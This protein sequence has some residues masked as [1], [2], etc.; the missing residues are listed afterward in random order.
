MI[1]ICAW[2]QKEG[3]QS[4]QEQMPE[5]SFGQISHGICRNHALSLRHTFRRSLLRQSV[6]TSSHLSSSTLSRTFQ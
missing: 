6:S 5:S 3:H 1:R 2:C 4:N